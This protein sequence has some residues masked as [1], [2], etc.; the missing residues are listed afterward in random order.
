MVVLDRRIQFLFVDGDTI[1]KWVF[2]PEIKESAREVQSEAKV[3]KNKSN[4][5]VE[6]HRGSKKKRGGT[7]STRTKSKKIT[8]RTTG[9]TR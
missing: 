2:Q 1:H 9:A 3:K 7:S 5:T 4:K 6:A 8:T